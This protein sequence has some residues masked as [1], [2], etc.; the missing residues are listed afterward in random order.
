LPGH[1]KSVANGEGWFGRPVARRIEN[2]DIF[3]GCECEEEKEEG[4]YQTGHDQNIRRLK[5]KK[6]S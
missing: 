2:E 5:E 4:E 3:A 6:Y 1:V